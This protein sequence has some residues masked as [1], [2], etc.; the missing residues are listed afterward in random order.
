MKEFIIQ[1][2]YFKGNPMFDIYEYINNMETTIIKTNCYGEQIKEFIENQKDCYFWT[3]RTRHLNFIINLLDIN[4]LKSNNIKWDYHT[5]AEN[6][7]L[8]EWKLNKI[9]YNFVAYWKYN[10]CE[11]L[12]NY[13]YNNKLWE[14]F[15]KRY[16]KD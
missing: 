8:N 4:I 11:I 2:N 12:E 5:D 1:E 9:S 15:Y 16:I 14:D 3:E 10:D 6:W 13:K 7:I